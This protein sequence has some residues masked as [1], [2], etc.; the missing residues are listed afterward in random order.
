MTLHSAKG[1]EFPQVFLV[2]MEEGLFPSGRSLDESGRLEEERRLAYV[3]LTRARRKLVLCY[4]ESRRIH[5]TELL[6]TPSRFL[7]EIPPALLHEVRP[8]VQVSRP[9]YAGSSVRMAHPSL[10][11]GP[12]LRLGQRVRHATFGTGIV[13]D[14]EGS[15]AHARAGQL[16]GCGLEVAGAGVREPGRGV[17]NTR[18]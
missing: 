15:G 5:G 9:A 10:A 4:A 3:G 16:R 18:S 7:R 2:G 8:K 13:T 14:A 11:E 17:S 1:L 6:G 12:S